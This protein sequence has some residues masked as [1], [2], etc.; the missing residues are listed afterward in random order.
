MLSDAPNAGLV[1]DWWA[2]LRTVLD[3]RDLA[4]LVAGTCTRLLLNAERMGIDEVADRLGRRLAR[5][6]EPAEAARW[7]EGFL[8][9]SPHRGGSGLVLATAGPCLA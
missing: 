5:G 1:V 9:P 7:I 3:R 4:N 6:T 2:A 8:S